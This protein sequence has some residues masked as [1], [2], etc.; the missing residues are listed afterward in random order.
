MSSL[1]QRLLTA[2]ALI[3]VVVWVVL[4]SPPT[5]FIAVLSVIIFIAAY[6]W[7]GLSAITTTLNKCV[8]AVAFLVA[9]VLL[10]QLDAGFLY[11]LMQISLAFWLLIV[12]LVIAKPAS[13]LKIP[14]SQSIMILLGLMVVSFTYV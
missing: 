9:A 6:E 13:L 4:Y 5:V 2:L 8:L 11:V 1:I 14:L 7:A 3:P 12:A 10:S